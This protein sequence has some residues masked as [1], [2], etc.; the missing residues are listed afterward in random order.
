M[1][2]IVVPIFSGPVFLG[3]WQCLAVDPEAAV[4]TFVSAIFLWIMLSRSRSGF[5]KSI[6]VGMF[7]LVVSA[8]WWATV[9]HYHGVEPLLKGAA[10]GQKALAVFHLLFF[11][12]TEEPYA[13]M[14]AILGLIGIADRTRPPGLSAA[15]LD[16][17][18][19]LCG[20]PQ[21]R[22]SGCHSAGD[23]GCHWAAGCGI[24]SVVRARPKERCNCPRRGT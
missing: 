1:K 24:R 10:T 4:H 8:P 16:G 19:I 15:L 17:H 20:G 11:V 18:P 7:V 21:C 14:I 9:I 13:T 22:G 2:K 6:V 23:A 3:D 12:F 5:I